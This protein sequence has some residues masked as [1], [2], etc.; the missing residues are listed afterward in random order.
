MDYLFIKAKPKINALEVQ[1]NLMY[2]KVPDIYK[3]IEKP[4]LPMFITNWIF[5]IGIIEC[6]MGKSRRVLSFMYSTVILLVYCL[7]AFYAY[8]YLKNLNFETMKNIIKIL[9]FSSCLLTISTTTLGW[10]RSK[11]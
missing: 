6:P 1:M 2:E 10:Y 9:F 3:E 7:V 5:G 8:P 4:A 11:V